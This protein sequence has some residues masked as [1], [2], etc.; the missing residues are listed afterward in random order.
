[1]GYGEGRGRVGC[2]CVGG[3]AEKSVGVEGG[4]FE[5][6]GGSWVWVCGC[7]RLHFSSDTTDDIVNTFRYVGELEPPNLVPFTRLRGRHFSSLSSSVTL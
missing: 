3:R 6:G 1:M 2:L 5:R 4:H 7:V